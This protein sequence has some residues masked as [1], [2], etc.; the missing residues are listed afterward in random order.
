M[1]IVEKKCFF[2]VFKWFQAG[3]EKGVWFE[4]LEESE[5]AFSHYFFNY[6]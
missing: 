3:K 6:F 5:P 1:K 2:G 4:I